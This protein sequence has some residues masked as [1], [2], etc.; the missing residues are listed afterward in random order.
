[1]KY[2][3][4]TEKPWPVTHTV[5]HT[6]GTDSRKKHIDI[7]LIGFSVKNGNSDTVISSSV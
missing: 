5:T 6:F 4:D 2:C 7:I 3:G 1:M